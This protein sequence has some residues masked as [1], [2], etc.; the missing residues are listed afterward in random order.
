MAESPEASEIE[1]WILPST[2]LGATTATGR[3]ASLRIA[4]TASATVASDSAKDAQST[5]INEVRRN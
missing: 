5:A 4:A 1:R 3:K 2:P